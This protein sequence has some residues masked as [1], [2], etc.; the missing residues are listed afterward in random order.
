L[1]NLGLAF[2]ACRAI[3]PRYK[4][5][6]DCDYDSAG[7]K[8]SKQKPFFGTFLKVSSL[9]IVFVF[10][11]ALVARVAAAEHSKEQLTEKKALDL[12]KK[13]DDAWIAGDAKALGT[14][15]ADGFVFVHATG[16]T[17]LKPEFVDLVASAKLKIASVNPITTHVTPFDG[18]ALVL[19]DVE[20]GLMAPS[21]NGG[22]PKV[23]TLRLRQSNV[24]VHTAAD[25]QLLLCQ[26]SPIMPPGGGR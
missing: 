11:A 6:D 8:M 7:E 4:W 14:L 3:I 19:R 24:W 9:V 2:E 16:Q 18:G 13:M 17:T 5:S 12:Q 1:L 10:T 15:L 26:G 20:Y 22:A 21:P 23:V 25:W